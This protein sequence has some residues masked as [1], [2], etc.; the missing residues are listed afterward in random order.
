MTAEKQIHRRKR[1]IKK[2]Q[3][4]LFHIFSL[5]FFIFLSA[6]LSCLLCCAYSGT[7]QKVAKATNRE[8]IEKKI[9]SSSWRRPDVLRWNV[10]KRGDAGRRKNRRVRGVSVYLPISRLLR[11]PEGC[12][13]CMQE[14]TL[15]NV[16]QLPKGKLSYR[17]NKYVATVQPYIKLKGHFVQYLTFCTKSFSD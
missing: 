12:G 11:E 7:D 5:L 1:Q 15:E 16:K 14:K 2:Q 10:E 4:S 17:F 9:L 3:S 8:R 6:F 13:M